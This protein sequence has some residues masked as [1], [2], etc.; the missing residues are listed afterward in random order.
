MQY[1]ITQE[2]LDFLEEEEKKKST[3][4]AKAAMLAALSIP[5]GGL[6]A[7]RH[8]ASKIGAPSTAEEPADTA[9]GTRRVPAQP[10]DKGRAGSAT[11]ATTKRG[12]R[13]EAPRTGSSVSDT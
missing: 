5:V 11:T 12:K 13:G 9:R 1:Y 7:S 10:R 6:V 3:L 8:I 4:G 2:G